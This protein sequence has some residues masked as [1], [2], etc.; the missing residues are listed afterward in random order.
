MR[1]LHDTVSHL[2]DQGHRR[3]VLDLTNVESAD[4]S[5][6]GALL[7]VVRVLGEGEG[8]VFL[9]RPPA[10]LRDS[11]NLLRATSVLH[12]VDDETDLNR[13]LEDATGGLGSA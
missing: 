6:I 13:R 3:V 2:A 8:R 9:L 12:V 10:R 11:L 7:D 4:S 5:G 1:E